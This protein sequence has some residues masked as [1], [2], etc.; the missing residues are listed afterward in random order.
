MCESRRLYLRD[1]SCGAPAHAAASN[2]NGEKVIVDQWPGAEHVA[3]LE[4]TV[5]RANVRIT[6]NNAEAVS[7]QFS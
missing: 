6:V 2:L 5:E 1:G 7:R 4:M 3:R